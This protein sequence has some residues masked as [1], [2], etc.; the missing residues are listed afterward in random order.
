MDFSTS[1]CREFPPLDPATPP[2]K[3]TDVLGGAVSENL[4][5]VFA[6]SCVSDSGRWPHSKQTCVSRQKRTLRAAPLVNKTSAPAS[7]P[8]PEFF[9]STCDKPRFEESEKKKK[10]RSCDSKSPNT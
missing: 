7:L 2:L 8:W 5:V 10:Q 1:V 9:S 6:E 3:G 4:C